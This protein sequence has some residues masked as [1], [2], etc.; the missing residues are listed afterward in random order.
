MDKRNKKTS[1]DKDFD[2]GVFMNIK[3]DYAFK[4]VFFNKRLLISFL[5]ALGTL[6]ETIVDLEY[7]SETQLGYAETN[8]KAVYDVYVKTTSGKK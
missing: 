5:N 7:L 4:T 8:R 2:L 6:P 1:K 3:T